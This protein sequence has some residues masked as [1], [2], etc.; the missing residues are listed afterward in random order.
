MRRLQAIVCLLVIFTLSRQSVLAQTVP[1]CTTVLLPPERSSGYVVANSTTAA[2]DSGALID[3][4][5]FYTP[6]AVR[7]TGG[8]E[9]LLQDRITRSLEDANRAN[10]N[11]GVTHRFRLVGLEHV[12]Y[13][14]R[15]VADRRSNPQDPNSPLID[16]LGTE[17]GELQGAQNGLQVTDTSRDVP[18][19]TL[20]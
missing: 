14:D 12:N 16:S 1:E 10:R 9:P 17:L 7:E 20:P 11:T 6:G 8:D 3:V 2:A 5:I 4:L 13:P 19:D 18:A 15:V